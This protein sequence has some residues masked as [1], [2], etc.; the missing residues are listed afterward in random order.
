MIRP[1]ERE[2]S[3]LREQKEGFVRR[4]RDV[5]G[6]PAAK[7]LARPKIKPNAGAR[8]IDRTA[9]GIAGNGSIKDS[10]AQKELVVSGESPGIFW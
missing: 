9:G 5:I 10:V 2:R 6:S 4:D 1:P 8:Q 3:R 7:F